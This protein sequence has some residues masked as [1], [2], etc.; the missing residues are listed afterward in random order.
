MAILTIYYYLGSCSL[1][2]DQIFSNRIILYFMMMRDGRNKKRK[3]KSFHKTAVILL[4]CIDSKPGIRYRQ[5]LRRTNLANGILS[6]HLGILE[7]SK[8]IKIDRSRYGRTS[9]IQHMSTKGI[10]ESLS[11]FQIVPLFK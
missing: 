6:Y 8:S 9:T 5:L 10:G 2:P 7:K 4:K 11:V 1:M 3:L